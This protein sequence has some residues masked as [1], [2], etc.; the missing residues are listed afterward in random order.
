MC[1]SHFCFFSSYLRGP[2]RTSISSMVSCMSHKSDLKLSMHDWLPNKNDI[3]Y[4]RF[5]FYFLQKYFT[6]HK[7]GIFIFF[8]VF[9]TSDIWTFFLFSILFHLLISNACGAFK[10]KEIKIKLIVHFSC[11]KKYNV[12]MHVAIDNDIQYKII[13]LNGTFEMFVLCSKR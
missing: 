11:A 10:I 2:V 6:I 8:F 13:S 12:L 5:S 4:S 9:R 1:K 7:F 3:F